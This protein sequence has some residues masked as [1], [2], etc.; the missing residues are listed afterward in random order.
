MR[1]GFIKQEAEY[2]LW[3]NYYGIMARSNYH[4]MAN[5]LFYRENRMLN[6][7]SYFLTLLYCLLQL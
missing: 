1:A 6:V 5:A 4:V 2:V 3:D 7:C